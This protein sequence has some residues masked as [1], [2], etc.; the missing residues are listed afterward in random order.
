MHYTSMHVM[1]FFCLYIGHCI[2]LAEPDYMCDL[3]SYAVSCNADL[4]AKKCRCFDSTDTAACEG[5]L[6]LIGN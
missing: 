5:K 2:T 6:I 4:S 3:N 1:F